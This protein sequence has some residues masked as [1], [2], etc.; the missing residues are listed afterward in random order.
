LGN[1]SEAF[2]GNNFGIILSKKM[3]G[4]YITNTPAPTHTLAM[5][6]TTNVMNFFGKVL[7]KSN[8]GADVVNSNPYLEDIEDI[9]EN[10]TGLDDDSSG[11]KIGG[12]SAMLIVYAILVVYALMVAFRR[13]GSKDLVPKVMEMVVAFL[14]PVTYIIVKN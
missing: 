14:S 3:L 4:V 9:A 1:P 2:Y 10:S 6:E 11:N 13:T 8:F 12:V 7:S 5:E